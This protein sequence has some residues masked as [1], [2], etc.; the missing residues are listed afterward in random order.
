MFFQLVLKQY[1]V[2]LRVVKSHLGSFK[3]CDSGNLQK[4]DFL[5]IEISVVCV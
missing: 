1:S 4:Y 2:E 3:K 5:N